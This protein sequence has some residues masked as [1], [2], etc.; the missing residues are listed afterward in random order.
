MARIR[1]YGGDKVFVVIPDVDLTLGSIKVDALIIN[2]L[3]NIRE[4]LLETVHG[5][6]PVD[7]G[8]LARDGIGYNKA[9]KITRRRYRAMVGLKKQP[10]HGIFVHDG[11]GIYGPRR[12]RIY[13]RT[14]PYLKFTIGERTFRLKSV[15]GQEPQP[16]MDEAY[17]IINRFF[18]P[19]EV[20]KLA[21]ALRSFGQR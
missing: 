21:L 14:A 11:T 12:S 7:S 20:Q 17:Q 5:L 2:T 13:P 1:R 19:L 15:A 16:F 10:E 6:V 4:E 9:K 8:E 18:V 3:D